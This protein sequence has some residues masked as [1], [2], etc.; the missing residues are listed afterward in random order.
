MLDRY[1]W[2]D[3]TRISP[4]APVPV[5]RVLRTTHVPGG[6]ANVALN[7]RGLGVDVTVIG[8]VGSDAEGEI[9]GRLLEREG[10][11]TDTVLTLPERPTV[12]KTRVMGGKQQMVRMDMEDTLPVGSHMFRHVDDVIKSGLCCA[13][14]VVLSDYGK[15][16]LSSEV[17]QAVIQAA[18][19]LSIPVIGDPKGRDYTKYAGATALT[20]NRGEL[21]LATGTDVD[22]INALIAAGERLRTGLQLSFLV[23]TRGEEGMTLLRDGEVEHFPAGAR[24]VFDVSGA[25]D[26]A[27]ATLAAGIA[28][29]MTV[30]TSVMLAN[31]AAGI[32]IGKV[33]TSAISLAEL[34]QAAFVRGL[35]DPFCRISGAI[36]PDQ[37]GI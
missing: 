31:H 23:F 12:T 3:V 27:I 19:Q 9:L 15:G 8:Y 21:A 35:P 33:G 26:T 5:V 36:S 30:S 6:A 18:Q 34:E 2:G 4:E 10:I 29:G 13:D 25:G 22:D 24:E 11:A 7:L 14:V 16:V 28:A 32:V 20:P 1:V 37:P 17:S